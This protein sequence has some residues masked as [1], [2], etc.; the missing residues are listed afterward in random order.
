MVT[1]LG[2]AYVR[3]FGENKLIADDLTKAD[4]NKYYLDLTDYVPKDTVG[5]IIRVWRVSGTGEFYVYPNE[6]PTMVSLGSNE[7]RSSLIPIKKRRLQYSLSVANDV[8]DIYLMGYFVE[9]PISRL[10]KEG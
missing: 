1:K 5:V 4:T 2:T 7:R 10:K 9:Y 8:F 3:L 6:G